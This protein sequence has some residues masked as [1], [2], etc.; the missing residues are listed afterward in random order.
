M[1]K[2]Y[3]ES[4]NHAQLVAMFES[5]SLYMLCLPTLQIEANKANMIISESVEN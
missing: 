1:I 5:E 4:K 2:V 3:F